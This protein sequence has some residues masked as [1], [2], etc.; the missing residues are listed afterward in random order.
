MRKS[1]KLEII[2]S[3]CINCQ[4]ERARSEEGSAKWAR[5]RSKDSYQ[6]RQRQ[7]LIQ[8]HSKGLIPDGARD[9]G[10]AGKMV[11]DIQN[12]LH[13]NEAL[14]DNLLEVFHKMQLGE[15][16]LR[17]L[18]KKT[19]AN[20]VSAQSS[21]AKGKSKLCEPACASTAIWCSGD[22]VPCICGSFIRQKFLGSMAY[23]TVFLFDIT[24]R[25][26]YSI[27]P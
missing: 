8:I 6:W 19:R 11:G 24:I 27:L 1:P 17:A 22:V 16:L 9:S 3:H 5:Q 2:K 20:Q 26:R 25:Q 7:P 4:N 18:S 23:S 10:D 13:G 14:W 21:D 12:R 15:D